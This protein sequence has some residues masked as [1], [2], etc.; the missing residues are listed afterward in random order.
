[1]IATPTATCTPTSVTSP[2]LLPI[3]VPVCDK[4]KSVLE[5]WDIETG[6]RTGRTAVT[7]TPAPDM[8]IPGMAVPG[9]SAAGIPPINMPAPRGRPALIDDVTVLRTIVQTETRKVT[10]ITERVTVTDAPLIAEACARLPV[11]SRTFS[12]EQWKR[13][14][15]GE[16]YRPTCETKTAAH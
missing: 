10:L 1:M 4:L 5:I 12:Q 3:I 16:P 13:E 8:P 11:D 9:T 7:D 2:S 6:Q 14:L 15:P